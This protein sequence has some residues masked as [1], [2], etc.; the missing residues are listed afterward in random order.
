M[1]LSSMSTSTGRAPEYDQGQNVTGYQAGKA[2]C[3]LVKIHKLRFEIESTTRD[4]HLG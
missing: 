1:I 3:Q 2:D 4:R